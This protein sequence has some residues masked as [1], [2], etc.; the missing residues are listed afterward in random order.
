MFVKT[1][2][3]IKSLF[4]RCCQGSRIRIV[5]KLRETKTG[6]DTQEHTK[7]IR[8]SVRSWNEETEK[9][10][11]RG[12]RERNKKQKNVVFVSRA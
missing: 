4:S 7:A 5:V 8:D 12:E 2:N 6:R 11:E 3:K 10:R 1:M 9:Q